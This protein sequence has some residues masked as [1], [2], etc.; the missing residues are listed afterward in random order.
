MPSFQ[1][2]LTS[3]ILASL[4]TAHIV[5]E[6]PK[7]YVFQG[8]GKLNPV[9][10][11]GSDF[12][13]RLPPGKSYIIDGEPTPM[14]I[15]E[16]QF[17]SFSGHAV[18]SG[19][20]CQIA[21]SRGFPT[22]DS[23]WMVIHSI[24][25]GCPAR[26]IT[27][28]LDGDSPDKYFFQIPEDIEP[29]TNWTLSYI[30]TSRGGSPEYY[31]DCSP[32]TILPS[33][34][35]KR[36]ALSERR[37]ALSKRAYAG[38]GDYPDLFMANMGDVSGGCTTL[39]A[40]HE[41]LSVAFPDPGNSVEQNDEKLFAQVCDGNPRARK[42]KG[43]KGSASGSSSS[44]SST[45]SSQTG[46]STSTSTPT[47]SASD[48][49]P[50][51]VSSASPT[52]SPTTAATSAIVISST[53]MVSSTFATSFTSSKSTSAST[54]PMSTT[55][56]ASAD[57]TTLLTRISP[58]VTPFPSPSPSASTPATASS[59]SAS[60][61]VAQ[62]SHTQTLPPPPTTGSCVEG[63]LTCLPDGTHFATCTGGQLTAPQPIAP[64]YKCK[65]GS[66]VGLDI[67]PM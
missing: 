53:I 20:S 12:P 54:P 16:D 43:G 59:A 28:N 51:K 33:D 10:A 35:T 48:S 64:G 65:V 30:W 27:G 58:T 1:V 4:S 15:G 3:A 36:M 55:A 24:E 23:P 45:G 9:S 34:K 18:H 6:N 60:A 41:M 11:S 46:S 66:G 14:K 52:T 63:Q 47:T 37:D 49:C 21:L 50:D 17:I 57:P 40:Q 7:P 8:D 38:P 25:G 44:S 62:P 67:S 29:G 26:N 13:C 5:L 22:K 32:V 19:G 31:M 39:D 2:L 42:N 61:S 56:S